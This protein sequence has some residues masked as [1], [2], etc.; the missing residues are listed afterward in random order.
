MTETCDDV[1]VNNIEGVKIEGDEGTDE[2][3][4]EDDDDH[5]VRRSTTEETCS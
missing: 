2:D 5:G 1:M 4:G 3:A